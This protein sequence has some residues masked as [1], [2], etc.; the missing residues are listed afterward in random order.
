[1]ADSL[2][3]A[4]QT[5]LQECL[6]LAQDIKSHADAASKF[7]NLRDSLTTNPATLTVIDSLWDA[8][9]TSRRASAFWEQLSDAEQALSQR[10]ADNHVQLQQ[11]YLRLVQE[12]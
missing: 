7:A 9:L 10:L 4:Q 11:N 6:E 3:P 12:Q 1:M 2:T 8:V 5:L